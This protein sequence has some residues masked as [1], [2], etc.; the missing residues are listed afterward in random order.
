MA[1]D[2]TQT[3]ADLEAAADSL[4]LFADDAERSARET[5]AAASETLRT[6]AA[7]RDAAIA[8]R[9]RLRSWIDELNGVVQSQGTDGVLIW[10][11]QSDGPCGFHIEYDARCAER[12]CDY[13]PSDC[14]HCWS[15]RVYGDSLDVALQ[16]LAS[17]SEEA[18]SGN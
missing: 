11:G 1:T 5:M 12:S 16:R 9:D 4:D 6:I 7:E 3:V 8:D 10:I 17:M 2:I 13:E 18:R 14:P 15:Q